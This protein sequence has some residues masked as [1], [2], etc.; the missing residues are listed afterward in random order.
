MA[1]HGGGRTV[2]DVPATAPTAL[3]RSTATSVLVA[4]PH[5]G[6]REALVGLLH[7]E[8][9]VAV[10]SC[11]SWAELV[12]EVVERAPAVVLMHRR[13]MGVGDHHA[14]ATLRALAPRTTVLVAG[15]QA[16]AQFAP[17]AL[18]AGASGY[19]PLDSPPE[20]I[21]AAIGTAAGR[22]PAVRL[23]VCAG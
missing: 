1:P 22:A 23:A 20:E 14:I 17:E 5:A 15:M 9:H 2:V 21:I 12:H 6:L 11:R 16:D 10:T 13:L 4:E 18:R 19:V 7:H 3:V 8:Q